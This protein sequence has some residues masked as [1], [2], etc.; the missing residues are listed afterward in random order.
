MGPRSD[1]ALFERS[2]LESGKQSATAVGNLVVPF[3]PQRNILSLG[4]G[5]PN[6]ALASSVSSR[7]NQPQSQVDPSKGDS[8]TT[9]QQSNGKKSPSDPLLQ[10]R[11]NQN[12]Y[13]LQVDLYS[14]LWARI[15]SFCT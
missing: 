11:R 3:S 13:V 7:L 10:R 4:V 12:A 5:D 14:L 6:L 1:S 15:L 2:L 9:H 8:Q